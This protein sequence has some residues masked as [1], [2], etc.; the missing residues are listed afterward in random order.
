[1]TDAVAMIFALWVIY[2]LLLEV[3]PETFLPLLYVM[4]LVSI[5]FTLLG[6]FAE[7]AHSAQ[8]Y[9]LKEQE[10]KQ[11]MERKAFDHQ[12]ELARYAA[13][14]RRVADNASYFIDGLGR[15]HPK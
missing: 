5:L 13:D 14:V 12:A 4:A 9:R 10:H 8:Q 15:T 1:M 2:F 6:M 3:N 7:S 11:T